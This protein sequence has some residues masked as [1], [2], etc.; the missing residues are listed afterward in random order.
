[1]IV[2]CLVTSSSIEGNNPPGQLASA[3]FEGHLPKVYDQQG[4]VVFEVP[5]EQSDLI[6][7]IDSATPIPP[8]RSRMRTRISMLMHISRP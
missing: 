4:V 2:E 7:T 8:R 6:Q 1:M 5:L 3:K